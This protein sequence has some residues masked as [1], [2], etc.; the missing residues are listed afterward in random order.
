MAKSKSLVGFV[1]PAGMKRLY[2]YT[3]LSPRRQV[4]KNEGFPSLAFFAALQEIF[5]VFSLAPKSPFSARERVYH[6]ELAAGLMDG[7]KS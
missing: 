6:C 7:E 3:L 1:H 2:Q 4:A 5:H